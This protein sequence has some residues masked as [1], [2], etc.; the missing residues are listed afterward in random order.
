MNDFKNLGIKHGT[1]KVNPHG[2]NFFYP[3]YLEP[4]RGDEFNMLEIGYQKGFSCKINFTR[5]IQKNKGFFSFVRLI[6]D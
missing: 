4:F 6:G 5:K 2:Y 3:R 1:D